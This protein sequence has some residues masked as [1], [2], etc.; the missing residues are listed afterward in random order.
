MILSHITSGIEQEKS[1]PMT[2][3]INT[4]QKSAIQ[5]SFID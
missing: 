4:A 1:T 3:D 5:L 2:S